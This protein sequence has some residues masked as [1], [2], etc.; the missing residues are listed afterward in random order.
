MNKE[1]PLQTGRLAEIK[2]E[3]DEKRA[4]WRAVRSERMARKAELEK[5]GLDRA[6]IRKDRLHREL[7][8][9]QARLSTL[10]KHIEKRLNKKRAIL[11]KMGDSIGVA[12]MAL[13]LSDLF[14]F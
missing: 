10:I 1:E 13:I 12:V 7:E 5:E 11:E 14:I 9:R 8:K 2:R 3:L 4:E 6:A